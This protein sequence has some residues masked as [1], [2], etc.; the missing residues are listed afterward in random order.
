MHE[1][2]RRVDTERSRGGG[3]GSGC[4][5]TQETSDPAL[6]NIVVSALKFKKLNA[7]FSRLTLL[8]TCCSSVI[9]AL[10]SALWTSDFA[11]HM[12]ELLAALPPAM[13]GVAGFVLVPCE[14]G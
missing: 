12:F 13:P 3:G 4:R 7:L 8:R 9:L 10:C 5:I 6:M 14:F 2:N 11:L 1:N